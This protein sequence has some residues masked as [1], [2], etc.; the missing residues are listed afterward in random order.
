M[1]QYN[2]SEFADDVISFFY[3]EWVFEYHS[4]ASVKTYPKKFVHAAKV[5]KFAPSECIVIEDSVSGIQAAQNAGMKVIGFMGGQHFNSVVQERLLSAM[6]DFYC[7]ST[8][9]LKELLSNLN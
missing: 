3:F 4:K 5:N 8:L 9:E 2:A 6:A 1:I 7:Y